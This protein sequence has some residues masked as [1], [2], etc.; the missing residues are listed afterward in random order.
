MASD[1][2]LDMI[3]HRQYYPCFAV[4]VTLTIHEH[5]PDRRRHVHLLLHSGWWYMGFRFGP[6]GFRRGE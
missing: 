1:R 5:T 3:V 4:G 6:D 2:W